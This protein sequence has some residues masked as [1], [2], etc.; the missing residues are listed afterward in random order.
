MFP[1]V[2]KKCP[3]NIDYEGVLATAEMGVA[4]RRKRGRGEMGVASLRVNHLRRL[5]CAGRKLSECLR[6]RRRR[7]RESGAE[8]VVMD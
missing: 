5:W 8:R 6:H 3:W 2:L 1:N 4:D 7:E